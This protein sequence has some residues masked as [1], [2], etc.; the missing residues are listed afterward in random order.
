M[1]IERLLSIDSIR[2]EMRY[3]IQKTAL[4][5]KNWTAVF[6]IEPAGAGHSRVVIIEHYEPT[7]PDDSAAAQI[8]SFLRAGLDALARRY[9]A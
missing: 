6:C 7:D 8:R 9:V 5:V 2:R 4:P 1:Q 3:E